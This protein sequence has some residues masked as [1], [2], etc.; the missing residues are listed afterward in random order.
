MAAGLTG[1]IPRYSWESKEAASCIQ[2]GEPCVLLDCPLSVPNK[3]RWTTDHLANVIDSNFLC[4]VYCSTT[5]RFTYWD[6]TKNIN[7]YDFTPPT[8]KTR[9][10]FRQ[11]VD[12]CKSADHSKEQRYLQQGLVQE[13]GPAILGE[14][15]R[16]P[17]DAARRFQK[18]GRWDGLT[19][20][21]LLCGPE[22]AITPAHF[23]EQENIFAQLTGIKRVRLFP[24]SAWPRLYP[25]PVGHPS[26]RQSQVRLPAAPGA[27]RLDDDAD[28]AT[29]PAF[30]AAL[31]DTTAEMHVDLHPGECLY[32]PMYWWHQ[33]EALTDNVSLSWWY[34]NQDQRKVHTQSNHDNDGDGDGDGV[35]AG[36]LA[37]EK[38]HVS[39]VAVRRNTERLV[40]DMAGGGQAAHTFFLAVAG[41][42]LPVLPKGGGEDGTN[43]GGVQTLG[44][45]FTPRYV[46]HVDDDVRGADVDAGAEVTGDGALRT[47]LPR[48]AAAAAAV[49]VPAHW[50][51]VA[52]Q[53]VAFVAMVLEVRCRP[54]FLPLS[55]PLPVGI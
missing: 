6:E 36:G 37:I 9:M 39:L 3:E 24:P 22:G 29:Y 41:G 51:E 52:A 20:N 54:L 12:Y 2:Q 35:G 50:P 34:K 43:G 4:D 42:R 10:T 8:R 33:M 14:Y 48:D 25:Y 23:D 47:P 17:F 46:T 38:A 11:Y 44:I 55:R 53:A 19:T 40:G 45:A 21:L 31:D 13:M 15:M 7:G 5:G 32:V 27:A 30:S 28:E 49:T 1:S 16:F 26:D 18:V